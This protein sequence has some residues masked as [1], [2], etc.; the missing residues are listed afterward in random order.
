[1]DIEKK[2]QNSLLWMK[3]LTVLMEYP[4]SDL[5]TVGVQNTNVLVKLW[6]HSKSHQIWSTHM[7]DSGSRNQILRSA[8]QLVEME[9]SIKTIWT[10]SLDV[11]FYEYVAK[12]H[13]GEV[14]EISAQDGSRRWDFNSKDL[15]WKMKAVFSLNIVQK[16]N[17]WLLYAGKEAKKAWQLI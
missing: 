1:M 8:S 13:T 3:R 16:V 4:S 2:N 12:A 7:P 14:C 17:E 6:N 10:T 11:V 5:R 15:K 9:V